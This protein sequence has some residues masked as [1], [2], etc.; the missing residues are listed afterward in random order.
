MCPSLDRMTWSSSH[1]VGGVFVII[2]S[3][4]TAA[5]FA[6][7]SHL[8]FAQY[9]ADLQVVPQP[10]LFALINHW[11]YV[12]TCELRGH[13]SPVS[14]HEDE[15]EPS[16][17]MLEAALPSGPGTRGGTRAGSY[18]AELEKAKI[19]PAPSGV[20]KLSLGAYMRA[21][22]EEAGLSM[23]QAARQSGISEGRWRQLESGYQSVGGEKIPV[24]TTEETVLRVAAGVG[25]HPDVALLAAGIRSRVKVSETGVWPLPK[26]VTLKRDPA[27]GSTSLVREAHIT[28]ETLR[29]AK[30]RLRNLEKFCETVQTLPLKDLEYLNSFI[31][32]LLNEAYAEEE[33]LNDEHLHDL[34]RLEESSHDH[35]FNK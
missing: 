10:R 15:P 17:D 26:H 5:N 29:R 33:R 14:S 21:K 24:K 11:P 28:S 18:R 2:P 19:R 32:D 34:A 6:T 9:P 16:L 3:C 27:H 20:R 25:M 4:R 30:K 13:T 35:Y 1:G 31:E 7:I 8:C 22:R 12:D 23:R